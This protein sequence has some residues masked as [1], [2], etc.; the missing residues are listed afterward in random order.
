MAIA[1]RRRPTRNG[2]GGL[3]RESPDGWLRRGLRHGP[4]AAV[5][6]RRG[7][8][9]GR[10]RRLLRRRRRALL[11]IAAAGAEVVL[12]PIRVVQVLQRPSAFG[13]LP[14]G[15]H[16]DL[17]AEFLPQLTEPGDLLLQVVRPDGVS[18]GL[19]LRQVETGRDLSRLCLLGVFSPW[20]GLS[21]LLLFWRVFS[22]PTGSCFSPLFLSGVFSP[23]TPLFP[24]PFPGRGGG[25]EEGRGGGYSS[26]RTVFFARRRP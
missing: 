19:H 15:L 22:L 14:Q 23:Q 8:R 9:S 16:R 6:L 7:P 2:N 1:L 4:A 26:T 20:R 3:L 10:R 13:E 12:E 11:S 18:P 25:G 21:L 5:A 17:F 24:P